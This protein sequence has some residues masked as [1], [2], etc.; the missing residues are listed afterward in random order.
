MEK[1]FALVTGASRGVGRAVATYLSREDYCLIL[2]ARDSD[3][4]NDTHKE[5]AGT[6]HL[7]IAADLA[8]T[9]GVEHLTHSVRDA[10]GDAGLATF[11]HCA[12]QTPDPAAEAS[13]AETTAEVMEA[14]CRTTAIAGMMLLRGLKPLLGIP[15]RAHAILIATD[16]VIDGITGPPVFS[17][18]KTFVASIWRHPR[19]EYLR[20]GT[21]LTTI[22]PGNIATYDEGW[23]VAKWTLDDTVEAVQAELGKSRISLQD[24]IGVVELILRSPMA[25]ITEVRLV[26]LD[27]DYVP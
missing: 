16:W 10:V 5:L 3:T 19:T 21:V 8:T 27:P 22:I 14:H 4:L 1:R 25:A 15:A 2:T 11:V 12:A 23:E 20:Q 13:L 18:A 26:P 7:A 24:V 6:G 9:A 17:A